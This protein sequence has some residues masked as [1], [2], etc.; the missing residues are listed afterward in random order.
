MPPNMKST[1]EFTQRKIWI[2]GCDVHA[3]EH[4]PK[5]PC[6]SWVKYTECITYF[7]YTPSIYS[8]ANQRTRNE[9]GVYEC[10]SNSRVHSFLFPPPLPPPELRLLL[11]S[12]T[13]LHPYQSL[14]LRTSERSFGIFTIPITSFW[15][16]NSCVSLIYLV[17]HQWQDEGLVISCPC[18]CL[19]TVEWVGFKLTFLEKD[20][21][22]DHEIDILKSLT[23]LQLRYVFKKCYFDRSWFWGTFH[24]IYVFVFF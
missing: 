5:A 11:H 18:A 12:A 22:H 17:P 6:A 9:I 16:T 8:R 15:W 4:A 10:L 21:C 2:S 1:N 14:S 3:R 19:T 23:K 13:L 7:Q 24:K 20:I